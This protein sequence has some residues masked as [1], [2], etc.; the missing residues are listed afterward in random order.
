MTKQEVLIILSSKLEPL[1]E[2]IL[3]GGSFAQV[4]LNRLG[5]ERLEKDLV[6][7]QVLGLPVVQHEEK[8]G[9]EIGFVARVN[10][11]SPQ[12]AQAFRLWLQNRGMMSLTLP[13]TALPAWHLLEQLPF[14][15]RER[16]E[17][18]AHLRDL[19][20]EEQSKWIKVLEKLA[21]QV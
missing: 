11:K 15:P 10:L 16:L 14:L 3:D 1:G 8:S 21:Q 17:L 9:L 2:V 5:E 19:K 4:M 7:W 18:C 20:T 13:A 12:Y 6:E